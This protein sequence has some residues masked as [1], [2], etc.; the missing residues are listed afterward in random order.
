MTD[1]IK[2]NSNSSDAMLKL[3]NSIIE[4]EHIIEVCKS[5]LDVNDGDEA[6][7]NLILAI[8][9]ELFDCSPDLLLEALE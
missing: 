1:C 2:S 9:C 6:T 3:R 5:F 8:T 4:G 7:Q